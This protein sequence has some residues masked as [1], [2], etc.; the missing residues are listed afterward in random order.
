MSNLIN[1]NILRNYCLSNAIDLRFNEPMERHTSLKIGGPADIAIF[2]D[3]TSL[4]VI[5]GLL[6]Q[7]NIPYLIIGKGTNVLVK[8]E[9]IQGAVLF[10]EKM[11][12]IAVKTEE[13][14]GSSE[15]H[16]SGSTDQKSIFIQSGC[17]LQKLVSLSVEHGLS[18][19]EGLVGIPGSAGGAI[20][21]NAGSFGYEI[22]DVL[23]TVRLLL[24]DGKI[25]NLSRNDVEFGY[26]VSNLP[27]NSIIL[28][29]YISLKCYDR[30]SIVKKVRNYLRE[31]SLTQPISKSS[32]GC[33]FKNPEGTS[34]GRLIDQAGC[35][36][37]REGAIEVSRLHANYFTN[38][39]GG[40]VTDFFRLMD[41]VVEKV[42]EQ[43]GIL[44][45]PEIKII[46]R[47]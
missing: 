26:R 10:T 21:G 43:F 7:Q 30:Q 41:F 23:R 37:M 46:G 47:S 42:K 19:V 20:A 31:K 25:I 24:A 3:E 16:A 33:V 29:A 11:N 22:K 6:T 39:G 9:G 17:P 4:P 15:E 12:G 40:K 34:A 28:G 8:N 36:G 35:K 32:A 13:Q 14:D 1:Y 27:F 45:E 2:P 18:G 38:S 44:L 5:I